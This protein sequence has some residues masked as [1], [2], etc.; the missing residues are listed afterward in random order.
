MLQLWLS[1]QRRPDNMK[2]FFLALIWLGCG[3]RL[4][5]ICCTRLNRSVGMMASWAFWI[6]ITSGSLIETLTTLPF[7]LWW[8]LKTLSPMKVL[9]LKYVGRLD[10]F[11]TTPVFWIISSE[12]LPSELLMIWTGE[13]ESTPPHLSHLCRSPILTSSS[14]QRRADHRL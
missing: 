10:L 13:T 3:R 12:L 14:R 7:C 4:S 2:S 1:H 6:R 11:L 9:F 8:I 5:S